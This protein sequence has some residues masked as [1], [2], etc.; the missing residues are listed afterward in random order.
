MTDGPYTMQLQAGLGLLDETKTLLHL[1]APGMSAADLEQEARETGHFSEVTARRLKNIVKECFAPRFLVDD[2]FPARLLKQALPNLSRTAFSQMCLVYTC[3]ANLILQDFV[4]QV[5]WPSYAAAKDCI[6]N[7]DARAFVEQSIR[8]GRT[9][10]AWA[11]KSRQ[12]ASAYLTGACADFGLLEGGTRISRKIRP[13]ILEP[14]TSYLIAY[15]LHWKGQT[16]QQ[17]IRS[18]D[19][20][21]FG[22]SDDDP[23]R[24]LSHA[25]SEAHLRVQTGGG[26]VSISWA[27]QTIEE[28]AHA[29]A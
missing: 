14:A 27:H 3:R 8:D 26:A 5:Y 22:L 24:Q 7:D 21:L 19:W 28:F 11:P 4:C 23:I 20:L 13:F 6:T 12:K 2:G 18:T 15:D 10:K 25:G 9:T 16:D 1:W 29:L 17:V